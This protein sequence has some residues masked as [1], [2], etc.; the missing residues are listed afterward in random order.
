MPFDFDGKRLVWL[1]YKD[2]D[3]RELSMFHFEESRQEMIHRF[4]KSD[5]MVSQVK[6][7]KTGD[8]QNPGRFLFFVKDCK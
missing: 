5:G 8:W 2:N 1:T 6:M 4:S 7:L 3:V